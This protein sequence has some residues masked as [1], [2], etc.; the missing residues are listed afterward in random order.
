MRNP[1]TRLRSAGYALRADRPTRCCRPS[2]LSQG[3]HIAS[4]TVGD[5]RFGGRQQV[6][7]SSFVLAAV[8]CL[9]ATLAEAAGVQLFDVPA[10]GAGPKLTGAVW[11]P[12]A[13]PPREIKYEDRVIVG[14][15]DCDIVG[16]KLPLIVVSHGRTAWFGA[17]HNTAAAL[18]DAGYIVAAVS[19]PGDNSFDHSRTDD[20]SV[21]VER[22]VDIRRL[23]DFMLG[24]WP[25]AAKI[26]RERIGLFGFSLGGYT[27]LVATGGNPDFRRDLPGCA[28]DH[29]RACEQLRNNE[30]PDGPLAHDPRIK[31]AVIVDPGPGIFFPADSLKAV[32]V[33]I[34]LWSSDPKLGARY[35]SGCCG[36]GIRN[37]LPSKPDFHLAT[38]A[39][40]VSFL[41]PCSA[42]EKEK[43]EFSRIC[44]DAPG[45][46][47]VAFHKDF[48]SDILAFFRK[49]LS[50]G[51]KP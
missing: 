9:A 4:D 51:T 2:A 39:I 16:S 37:R 13:T 29:L 32:N 26:D 7:R 47:R 25:D 11:Y 30:I 18:A 38:G 10:D 33:P 14:A 48:H 36:L 22:P 12:C 43:P 24:I 1:P 34:Q 35:M 46:D 42:D 45:F 31:A 5:W 20:L 50:E 41:A 49:T 28:G 23:L 27:G 19:H 44:T 15:K 17:H 40:H 3:R 21:F 6:F 8:L